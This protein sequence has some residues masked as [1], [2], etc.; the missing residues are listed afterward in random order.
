MNITTEPPGAEVFFKLYNRPEDMW[1]ILGVTPLDSVQVPATVFRWKIE[2]EG[3]EKVMAVT[4][5]YDITNMQRM[6]IADMFKGNNLHRVLDTKGSIPEGMTRVGG[7]TRP[8]GELGDFFIDKFEVSNKQYKNFI[9]MGGYQKSDYWQELTAILSDSMDWQEAMKYFVDQSGQPGPSTWKNQAY[10]EGENNYPVNGISWY[11]ANAYADFAG[12][13]LPTKDH[14]GRAR[15]EGT[16]LITFPQFGGNAIFTPF[17][18]FHGEGPVRCGSLPGLTIFG[19]YDMA[20]NVREWC[21][22]ESAQGRWIRGG[23]WNDNPYMFGAPSQANPFDRSERNGFRCTLYPNTDSIPEAAFLL[24]RPRYRDQILAEPISDEQFE[25]FKVYYDYDKTD[26]YDEV[27]SRKENKE[28]WILEKVEFDAAYDNERMATYMFLPTNVKPPYQ[29]V[30]YGPGANVLWQENSE[31][32]DNFFEYTAFLEYLVRSGRAVIFPII[33]GSFE[34]K[35]EIPA[36][37]YP[38]T[39]KFTSYITRVVKDY[40]RCLDYLETRNDFDMNKIA[41]YGVSMGTRLGSYLTAVE[42][43]IKT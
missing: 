38:E 29:T 22:N 18:N 4:M 24:A 14:W 23:D 34:R 12:K 13:S 31:D 6:R 11:E 42:P 39:H 8:Y 1:Q 36:F 5:T 9:H 19:A 25:V 21:W 37:A 2:K 3:Y 28:G 7:I 27:V 35:E 30:I 10:P 41:F 33:K 43:R 20:G 17:S 26:L 40:R 32:I 16:I 15:G